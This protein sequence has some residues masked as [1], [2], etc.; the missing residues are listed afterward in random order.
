MSEHSLRMGAHPLEV[1]RKAAGLTQR[2]VAERLATTAA[3]VSRIEQ[4]ERRPSVDLIVRIVDMTGGELTADAM[5]AA[6][7]ERPSEAA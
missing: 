7:R 6:A 1:W 3:T 5:I 2:E 4:R